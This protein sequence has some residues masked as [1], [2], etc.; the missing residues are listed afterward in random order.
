MC[1][2]T[3]LPGS[4]LWWWLLYCRSSMHLNKKI[5]FCISINHGCSLTHY[6]SFSDVLVM[7]SLLFFNIFIIGLYYLFYLNSNIRRRAFKI[8]VAKTKSVG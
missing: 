7:E 8:T 3:N 1:L 6:S 4:Y 5:V 2:E